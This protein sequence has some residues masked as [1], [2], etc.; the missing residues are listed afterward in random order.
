MD[1]AVWEEKNADYYASQAET[2]AAEGD[3]DNAA[4]YAAEA[5]E[6]QAAAD[7]HGTLGEHGGA[8]AVYDPSAEVTHDASYDYSAADCA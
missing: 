4:T 6:H 3:Y 5:G 8:M 7:Y 2:Y 1:W